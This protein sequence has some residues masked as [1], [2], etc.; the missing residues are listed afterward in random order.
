MDSTIIT[1]YRSRRSQA[2][3]RRRPKIFRTAVVVATRYMIRAVKLETVQ[4]VSFDA[5][6][7]L[8]LVHTHVSCRMSYLSIN[9]LW[10]GFPIKSARTV[11]Y[12]PSAL[13][14]AYSSY[15]LRLRVE[16]WGD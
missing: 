3:A 6:Q 12:K 8:R 9:R 1:Q 14:S 16:S 15:E 11:D 13:D 10:H 2:Q 5:R 7:Q 4:I